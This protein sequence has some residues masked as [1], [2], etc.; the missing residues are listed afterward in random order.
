VTAPAPSPRI[1]AVDAHHHLWDLGVS[2][3]AW[4]HPN[5]AGDPFP[6]FEK[7][8]RD[9]TI[10]DY[11]AEIAGHGIV[12]S[13][14][15]QAEHDAS[16]PV[17]ETTWLQ[18]IADDPRSGGF[19]HAIV[20]GADLMHPD[21]EAVLEAQASHANVRGIRQILSPRATAASGDPAEK[22]L[23]SRAAQLED[24]GFLRQF[25]LLRRF[26]LS[27]DLQ[28]FAWQR[29]E[30]KALLR[31]HDD[32]RIVLNHTLMPFDRSEEG[33]EQ[34]R[35]GL[36]FFADH[37]HVVLKISGLGM[38]P[39]GWDP[40]LNRRLVTRAIEAFGTDRCLFGSNFPIDGL[41]ADYASVWSVYRDAVEALSEDEQIAVLRGNAERIYRI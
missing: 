35:R 16:A 39:G 34:W 31:R 25:A 20:A 30:A 38:A 18:A 17:R 40:A 3:Y 1:G 9:Y 28:L 37:P 15:V 13:V 21:A 24:E 8:C 32:T 41:V 2:H 22:A 10:E 36:E 19:P 23:A 29:D 27:F 4:L 33:M 6:D 7:I 26:D 14:H 5:P 11:R 12:K